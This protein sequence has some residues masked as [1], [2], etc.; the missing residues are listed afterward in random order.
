MAKL[1]V[2]P[3]YSHDHDGCPDEDYN[4]SAKIEQLGGEVDVAR[5]WSMDVTL[6]NDKVVEFVCWAM[7]NKH[8]FRL[9][10]WS[11]YVLIEV[12]E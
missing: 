3:A 1:N 4:I 10:D 6:P 9:D 5:R 2:Q 11:G 12:R 8:L 7:T